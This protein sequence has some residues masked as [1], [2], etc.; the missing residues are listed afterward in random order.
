MAID[1]PDTTL[2]ANDKRVLGALFDPETLPSSVAR[3][4]DA[5]AIDAALPPHPS[6]SATQLSQL[7]AQQHEIIR[8]VSSNSEAEAILTAIA[9]LDRTISDWPNYPS[10]YV[11]RAM[12]RRMRIE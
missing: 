7:E 1:V 5:S 6:I 11:N 8:D 10:A 9:R 4:K 2:S 3:S 12:L